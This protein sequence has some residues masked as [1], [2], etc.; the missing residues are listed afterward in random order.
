[1]S[2]RA[3]VVQ[4]QGA[5]N[6]N[7]RN[8]VRSRASG[9]LFPH[10][11]PPT[12]LVF[13]SVFKLG[14]WLT[15]ARQQKR[16]QEHRKTTNNDSR[17][18]PKR[19]VKHNLARPACC[20]CTATPPNPRQT[21]TH[22]LRHSHTERDTHACVAEEGNP[23]TCKTQRTGANRASEREGA[24]STVCLARRHALRASNVAAGTE[25]PSTA[26][27]TNLDV[28][29]CVWMRFSFHSPPTL[30]GTA[31]EQFAD[32]RKAPGHAQKTGQGPNANPHSVVSNCRERNGRNATKKNASGTNSPQTKPKQN[33]NTHSN[34]RKK[35]TQERGKT[36]GNNTKT[37]ATFPFQHSPPPRGRFRQR[38]K[39]QAFLSL[40]IGCRMLE[41]GISFPFSAFS[42]VLFSQTTVL[43]S[44]H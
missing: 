25:R 18:P 22:S 38:K 4:G 44:R 3:L 40:N 11:I 8:F 12:Q 43:L 31:F 19:R 5:V 14:P 26:S 42:S 33:S 35:T 28:C 20:L 2:Q 34:T 6:D 30:N 29:V 39:C 10:A 16:K 9:D 13:L 15:H 7:A 32:D 27:Q 24:V 23:R 36:T 37:T 1:M 41:S 21:Y 17:S